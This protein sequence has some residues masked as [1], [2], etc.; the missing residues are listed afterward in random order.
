GRAHRVVAGDGKDP[1]DQDD[2]DDEMHDRT[3]NQH[4]GSLAGRLLVEGSVLVLRRELLER[5]HALD[6]HEAAGWDRLDAVLRLAA[7]ERPDRRPEAD[8]EPRRL[9]AVVLRGREV[10]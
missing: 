8:E 5:R 4:D 9:H 7:T 1:E 2:R 6:L 10:A 3:G